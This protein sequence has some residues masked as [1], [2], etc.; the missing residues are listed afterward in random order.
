M[1]IFHHNDDDG[2]CAAAVVKYYL[3]DLG[4]DLSDYDFIEYNHGGTID[5]DIS[6]IIK[7]VVYIVDLALDDTI[8]DLIMKLHANECDIIHIDHHKTTREYMET[9]TL[10][11]KAV[12]NDI[13][14]FY[15]NGVS[16]A[17]LTYIYASMY[18]EEREDPEEVFKHC[19]FTEKRGHIGFYP[20]TPQE[21]CIRIPMLIRYVD[22][23]D[24]WLYDIPE[25][26]YFNLAFS[27]ETDKHPNHDLWK[28]LSQTDLVLMKT[29]IPQGENLWKYQQAQ[30][31]HRRKD[32][33]DIKLRLSNG[34]ACV[35]YNVHALNARG[36]SH[37]FG[38]MIQNGDIYMIYHY[39]GR[40]QKWTCS[41]YTGENGIDVSGIAKYYGGG[42]HAHAAGFQL[43]HMNYDSDGILIPP[44]K[45]H[46]LMTNENTSND[47]TKSKSKKESFFTRLKKRFK[48]K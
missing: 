5:T 43:E 24:V 25:T 30:Y 45:H 12:M 36:N 26:K 31:E 46:S 29:Y 48:K 2:R 44:I 47:D 37:I 38:D 8:M 1:K 20:E 9:M 41:L 28:L 32:I 10:E 27:C 19:D 22:D 39:N 42:G 40:I 14:H 15:V 23:H 7:Q 16:G 11:Q 18:D 17:L 4:R 35:I 3:N 13:K 6:S 34:L 33:H 21:R